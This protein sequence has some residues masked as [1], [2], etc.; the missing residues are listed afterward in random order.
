[1]APALHETE[2]DGKHPTRDATDSLALLW[3]RYTVW[4]ERDEQHALGA[5]QALRE[6]AQST[7][8]QAGSV[9]HHQRARAAGGA[10]AVADALRSSATVL[11]Q[12]DSPAIADYLDQAARGVEAASRRLREED[13]D[14]LIGTA[15][16]YA[17]R[18]PAMFL[19]AS[20]VAGLALGRFLKSSS[21]RRNRGERSATVEAPAPPTVRR[22]D[23]PTATPR[24]DGETSA[25]ADLLEY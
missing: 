11:R 9:L 18:Q 2:R 14:S 5:R 8:Q 1:M 25:P 16:D 15:E 24:S 4:T 7:R 6:A 13:L 3:R 23:G 22:Y 21:A 19:G 17:R 12:S 20:V 10:H